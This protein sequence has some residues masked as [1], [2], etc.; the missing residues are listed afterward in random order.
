MDG[1]WIRAE[2]IRPEMLET[3]QSTFR[4]RRGT[5]PS[6]GCAVA[7]SGP[8]VLVAEDEAL[9][10]LNAI[11]MVEAAGFHAISAST[12]D[13]AIHVLELRDDIRA[14]FTDVQMPGSMDGLALI[15][16]MAK[17]WPAIAALITSGKV[18]IPPSDLPR[19]ARF[20]AKPWRP[21]QIEA[22]LRQAIG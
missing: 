9:I 5:R 2:P 6:M 20:F 8:T 21:V 12:A 14:V 4:Q 17:R 7:G 22:A 13:E 18:D 15:H 11:D 19:G 10:R 16:L 3:E 1:K